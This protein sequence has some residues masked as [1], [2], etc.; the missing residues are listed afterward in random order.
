MDK[1]L[2]YTLYFNLCP[3]IFQQ[4]LRSNL[5]RKLHQNIVPIWPFSNL[6]WTKNHPTHCIVWRLQFK[7]VVAT[8]TKYRRSVWRR[9]HTK[10]PIH[11]GAKVVSKSHLKFLCIY[12]LTRY[13]VC[14]IDPKFRENILSNR[15]GMKISNA[16]S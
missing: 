5:Q 3:L 13:F 1:Y 2:N 4:Y 16:T 10:V 6:V 8:I 9:G 12:G 7:K 14:Q 15:G 11:N